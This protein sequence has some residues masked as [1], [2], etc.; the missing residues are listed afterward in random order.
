M[1]DPADLQNAVDELRDSWAT[2]PYY[3]LAEPDM[4]WQWEQLI[5]PWVEDRDLSRVLELDPFSQAI[6]W[7]YDGTEENGFFSGTLGA[8]HRLANG[9]TLIVESEA[10]RAFEVTPDL[11]VVWSFFNPA[12]GGD[13]DELVAALYDVVRVPA[14]FTSSWLVLEADAPEV[15]R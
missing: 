14:A 8:A 12:R 5:A 1:S 10:G 7:A 2:A 6:R 9:N 11:E 3:E 4:K 13:D 15:P